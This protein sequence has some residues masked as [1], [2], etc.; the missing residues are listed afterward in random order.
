[1]DV[2][3]YLRRIGYD[4]SL[5]PTLETLRELHRAHLLNVPFENLDISL[6]KPIALFRDRLF[7]KIVTNGR[8]GFCYELNGLF[9]ELLKIL[10]FDVTLVSAR[11]TLNA[12]NTPPEFDHLALVVTLENEGTQQQWLADVGFGDSFMEPLRLEDGKENVQRGCVYQLREVR[13]G[14]WSARQRNVDDESWVGM[15]DFSMV[16]RRVADFSAMCR[17]HQSSPDSGFTKG[18]LCSIATEDGRKTLSEGQLIINRNGDR[19]ERPVE[20][21]RW[22]EMLQQE[23]GITLR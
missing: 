9:S 1:M 10:G 20:P 6:R 3:A 8:G 16:P 12:K 18:R 15:Y 11:V 4:G 2:G 14:E 22:Y 19:M 23:F 7:R 13:P 17:Y 21:Q 5:E